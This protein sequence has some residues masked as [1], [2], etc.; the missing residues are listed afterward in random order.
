MLKT[1]ALSFSAVAVPLASRWVVLVIWFSRLQPDSSRPAAAMV[2]TAITRVHR[3]DVVVID[4]AILV[5][6]KL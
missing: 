3:G 5:P 1:S 6:L 2:V 4:M